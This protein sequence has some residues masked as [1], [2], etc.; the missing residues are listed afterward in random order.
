MRHKQH[1]TKQKKICSKKQKQMVDLCPVSPWC[2]PHPPA[3]G[4]FDYASHLCL[5]KVSRVKWGKEKKKET[6]GADEMK[7]D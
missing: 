5:E 7:R 6:A 3:S 4:L 1:K 2:P